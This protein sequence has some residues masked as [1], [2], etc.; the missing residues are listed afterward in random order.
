MLEAGRAFGREQRCERHAAADALAE[1][2]DVGRDAGVLVVEELA[3]P[4]HAGL[5]LVEDQEEAVRVGE[6]AQLLQ[7][8]IGRRPHA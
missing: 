8:L 6:R 1:R 4:A 3:G 2:H 7:E 5:D